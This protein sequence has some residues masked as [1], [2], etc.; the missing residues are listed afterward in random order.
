MALSRTK[1]LVLLAIAVLL[2]AA[3]G[4]LV[5]RYVPVRDLVA[6]VNEEIPPWLFV[7]LMA[8][9]PL[10]GAPISLFY[11]LAG[12]VFPMG[13]GVLVTALVIPFH[14]AVFFLLARAVKTP[15]ETILARRGH[16]PPAIPAHRRASFCLIMNML[17]IPYVVK[18]YLQPLAGIRFPLFFWVSWPV[19][20]V[21]A[22]PMVLVGSAATDMDPVLLSIAVALFAGM[23]LLGRRIE[24]R[25][26]GVVP[27][28]NDGQEPSD[29]AL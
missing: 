21:L 18:N 9:L 17:P 14:L 27:I 19:Q 12:I 1:K 22:L 20:L 23:Y 16:R 11:A 24:K 4:Y 5:W 25:Y 15:I 6:L 29:T 10:V 7:C 3:F 26:A 28:Q 2:L 13:L 8:L